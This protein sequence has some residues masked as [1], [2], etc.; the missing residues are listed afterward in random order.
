MADQ[1]QTTDSE[2]GRAI[3][4]SVATGFF[5][6][7]MHDRVAHGIE[8]AITVLVARALAAE[9]ERCAAFVRARLRDSPINGEPLAQAIERGDHA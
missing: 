6:S 1:P 2:I 5:N 4:Q 7:G 9:R 3:A 8:S